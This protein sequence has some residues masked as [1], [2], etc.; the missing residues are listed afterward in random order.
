MKKPAAALRAKDSFTSR[1][2]KEFSAWQGKLEEF[3]Q[4]TERRWRSLRRRIT[5][6]LVLSWAL[7]CGA[8]WMLLR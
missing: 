8:L 2:S 7:A 6:G 3:Q 4:E 1:L 5:L